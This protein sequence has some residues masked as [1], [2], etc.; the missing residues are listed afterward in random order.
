MRWV[1]E[2]DQQI[3]LIL[4][5]MRRKLNNTLAGRQIFYGIVCRILIMP[6]LMPTSKQSY[7]SLST[8]LTLARLPMFT[9]ILMHYEL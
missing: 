2:V 8:L 3:V 9:F 5:K 7:F 1:Y 6:V 4:N